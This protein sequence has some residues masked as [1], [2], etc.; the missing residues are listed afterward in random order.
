[1][2]SGHFQNRLQ[3]PAPGSQATN[4][5]RGGQQAA[6]SVTKGPLSHLEKEAQPLAVSRNTEIQ[7]EA[8]PEF[9]QDSMQ[10]PHSAEKVPQSPDMKWSSLYPS[11]APFRGPLL[12]IMTA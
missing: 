1:M 10:A 6:A 2:N 7:A 12:T 3:T 11:G 5:G 9:P 4:R 8:R